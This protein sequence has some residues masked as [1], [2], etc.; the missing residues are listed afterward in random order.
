MNTLKTRKEIEIDFV[1]ACDQSKEL[2][3]ISSSLYRIARSDM[4]QTIVMMRS[5]WKGDN[6]DGFYDKTQKLREE[7]LENAQDLVK[8]ANHIHHTA[9]IIYNAEMI[10]IGVVG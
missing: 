6:A 1:K 3:D 8:I 5:G 2:I 9:D 7:L 10:A 4:A